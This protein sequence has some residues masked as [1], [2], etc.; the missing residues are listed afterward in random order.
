MT[1]EP[2]FL[3]GREVD[4]DSISRDL[5]LLHPTL[6]DAVSRAQEL[7]FFLF[8]GYRSRERQAKLYAIGRTVPGRRVTSARPGASLHQCGLAIDLVYLKNGRWS[9]AE[10]VPWKK[11]AEVMSREFLL[12][13]IP[14]ERPH[15]QVCNLATARAGKFRPASHDRMAAWREAIARMADRRSPAWMRNPKLPPYGWT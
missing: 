4:P 3:R 12:T 2:L 15:F 7:G 6:V 1:T 8:E 10:T 14:T 13:P 5:S 9:W 11:L